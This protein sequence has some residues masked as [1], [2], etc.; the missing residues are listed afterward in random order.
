MDVRDAVWSIAKDPDGAGVVVQPS[1]SR[2]TPVEPSA[3]AAF[4]DGTVARITEVVVAPLMLNGLPLGVHV[5][6]NGVIN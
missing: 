2:P 5:I 1:S 6:S 3:T 4:D